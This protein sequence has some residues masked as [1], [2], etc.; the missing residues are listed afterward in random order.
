[1]EEYEA[2]HRRPHR[3]IVVPG[4]ENETVERVVEMHPTYSVVEKRPEFQ[5]PG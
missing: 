1:V 2:V 5:A 4:H 3:F